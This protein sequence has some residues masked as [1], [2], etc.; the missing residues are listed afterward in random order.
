M[1]TIARN[2]NLGIELHETGFNVLSARLL[3]ECPA[4]FT[5]TSKIPIDPVSP[6]RRFLVL[7]VKVTDPVSFN[8]SPV[9]GL[10]SPTNE[11]V[12][13][14]AIHFQLS[15]LKCDGSAIPKCDVPPGD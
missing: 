3:K 14:V 11:V 1:G 4:W 8:F 15:D 9:A 5:K 6:H 10:P 2:F 12:A 7:E 13:R